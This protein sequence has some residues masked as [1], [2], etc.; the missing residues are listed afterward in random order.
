MKKFKI[1]YKKGQKNCKVYDSET[2]NTNFI[3]VKALFE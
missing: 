3:K 2:K 1:I